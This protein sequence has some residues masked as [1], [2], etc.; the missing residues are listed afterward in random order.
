MAILNFHRL[1]MGTMKVGIYCYFI[2][3]IYV[4]HQRGGGHIVFGV[5]PVGVGV[6]DSV[7]MTLSFLQDSS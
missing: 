7:G 4:P 5:D 1:V 6:S 3:Y 2:A